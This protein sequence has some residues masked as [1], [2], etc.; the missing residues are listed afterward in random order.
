MCNVYGRHC[1]IKFIQFRFIQN[2]YGK[3]IMSIRFIWWHFCYADFE[4]SNR[5]VR[6]YSLNIKCYVPVYVFQFNFALLAQQWFR[7]H[8]LILETCRRP[9]CVRCNPGFRPV[10]ER[11]SRGCRVCKCRSRCEVG[12]SVVVFM[13]NRQSC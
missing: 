2:V 3:Q 12:G 11:D 8:V 6:T 10:I 5:N 4:T 13:Q 9:K 7:R 1:V